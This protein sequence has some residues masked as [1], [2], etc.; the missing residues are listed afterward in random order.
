[1]RIVDCFTDVI[2][3]ARKFERQ[4]DDRAGVEEL[5]NEL[6]GLL[7]ASR[8]SAL[9]H[10]ISSDMHEAAMFAVVAY[11]DELLLCSDWEMRGEWQHEPL[12]R[13][14]FNTTSAG[15]EFYDRLNELNK[16]GPDRDVREVFALCLGLGYRG[17]YFRG[18][19]RKAYENAKAFNLSLLLPDEAQ[20]NIDSATLFP[21]AYKGHSDAEKAG[22]KPRLSVY[23]ILIGVPVVVVLVMALLYSY[24]MNDLLQQ[25]EALVQ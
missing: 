11:I 8:Q 22:F 14:Y 2:L 5:R 25:I 13:I 12:Q 1:M 4:Q 23:P 6:M 7:E 21:F 18:E 3:H 15:A 16:F 19:D 17:K 24:Y 20:R 10:G 9:D